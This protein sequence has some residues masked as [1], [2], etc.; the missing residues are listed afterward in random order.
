MKEYI[1]ENKLSFLIDEDGDSFES[2]QLALVFIQSYIKPSAYEFQNPYWNGSKGYFI[3]DG[4]TVYLEYS[5]WTGTV[6]RV[7]ENV[8][9]LQKVRQW[10]DEIYKA[11]HE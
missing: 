5:N 2:F 1:Y 3:K 8:N 4:I 7:D 9:D 6:L 10:A 11:A